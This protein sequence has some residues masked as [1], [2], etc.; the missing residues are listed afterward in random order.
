M[1]DALTKARMALGLQKIPCPS[2]KHRAQWL[3]PETYTRM[4]CTLYSTDARQI[5]SCIPNTYSHFE[6]ADGQ[7]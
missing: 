5:A 1:L 7:D 2:C 6:P 3:S 4:W